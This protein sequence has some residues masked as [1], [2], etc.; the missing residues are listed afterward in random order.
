[1]SLKT[2]RRLL[3]IY[4]PNSGSGK[5]IDIKSRIVQFEKNYQFSWELYITKGENDAIH[6]EQE[7]KKF[8]PDTVVAIGGDGTINTVASQIIDSNIALGIIPSGSANGLAFNLD[9]PKDFNLVLSM[10]LKHLPKPIDVI[11]INQEHLCLHLSDAGINARIV[12]RFEREGSKGLW[13]YACQMIKEIFSKKTYFRF[14]LGTNGKIKKYKAE[15]LVV[16]NAESFGTGA[17]INPVGEINDGK[18][19]LII[20]KPYPWWY[21]LHLILAIFTGSLNRLKNVS[22]CSTE[23]AKIEFDIPHDIQIDGEVH[24]GIADMDI[25]I[26]PQKL[27]VYY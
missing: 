3:F 21:M 6:I 19:E 27:E 9:V 15:M 8:K 5:G 24:E 11:E 7:I 20:I 18:F 26:L 17:K 13:G 10:I 25:K 23:K 4:N 16:A 2:N 12:K 14:E 1:M 22:I